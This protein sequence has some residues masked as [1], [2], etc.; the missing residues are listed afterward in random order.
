M[1]SISVTHLFGGRKHFRKAPSHGGP[2]APQIPW[3]ATEKRPMIARTR[4]TFAASKPTDTRCAEHGASSANG[5]S[6]SLPCRRFETRHRI[7]K[8]FRAARRP[9]IPPAYRDVL[10]LIQYP[11]PLFPP[12]NVRDGDGKPRR[13]S[14][15]TVGPVLS[16]PHGACAPARHF[17]P[18]PRLPKGWRRK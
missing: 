1:A 16:G 15:A 12:G 3:N 7:L 14:G 4:F 10:S 5:P 17:A 13:G 9:P 11:P 18:F 2:R 8:Q 6:T